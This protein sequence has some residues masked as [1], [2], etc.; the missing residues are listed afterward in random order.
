MPKLLKKLIASLL[1]A[2]FLFS[3]TLL[4]FS[5]IPQVSLAQSSST[6]E[7]QESQQTS[8]TPSST[9]QWYDQDFQSWYNKVYDEGNPSE[10]F[11]ERYTA[12]QVQW[13]VYSLFSFIM[14]NTTGQMADCAFAKGG[15]DQ[16]R[17]C[18][19]PF[20]QG[21]PGVGYEKSNK[22]QT[23]LGAIFEERPL[24]GITY[25]KN[26]GRKLRLVPEA[27]AQAAGFGFTALEPVIE[28][29][30]IAR[31]V[32]YA[33]LT[34]VIIAMAFMIMF[35]VKISP[36]VV[37]TVQSAI[38]KVV[39]AII[40]IT[41]SYAI[42]GFLVD[43]MYV[44]IGFAS[45]AL[46]TAY[47]NGSP[48]AAFNLMTKGQ[49][50]GGDINLGIF[51][52]FIVYIA[53]LIVSLIITIIVS[54]GAL[55]TA[56]AGLG[57]IFLGGLLSVS[58]AGVLP[59]IGVIA[60][61]VV[62]LALLIMFFKTL[63]ALLKAVA[64]TLLLT[65]AAPFQ[66]LLGTI[67]PKMGFGAWLRSYAANLS[68]FVVIGLF[69]QLAFLFINAAWT[70]LFPSLGEGISHFFFGTNPIIHPGQVTERAWP[71]L[72]GGGEGA[73]PILFL[74][75]SFVILTIIPKSAE[76]IKATIQGQPFAYG[77]GIKEA[78][79][80]PGLWGAAETMNI[81]E[82]IARRRRKEPTYTPGWI[83]VGR[84]ALGV[85]PGGQ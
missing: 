42:A 66:I 4:P 61:I 60:L 81:F 83:Q 70:S 28:L 62:I 35:R 25:I 31:N 27:K 51:G 39:L 56:A 45:L 3:S 19:E 21:L 5:S 50:W 26:I 58:T 33:L 2:S 77:T 75:V 43:L 9:L 71:P 72:L 41:F 7:S 30:K 69:F 64:N 57:I 67:V 52:L 13:I 22:H 63:W 16:I 40:L 80:P 14:R 74:G 12:A 79:G 34:L 85:K 37:I 84:R 24:S 15:V 29:W 44:V 49:P 54:L 59:I 73:V 48:V 53:L 65:I 36:Q 10:I 1:L 8:Q 17:Q 18:L 46:S 11:G 32:S 38:P 20:F 23:L 82:A 6:E 76:L 78:F 68:V 55:G 47:Q